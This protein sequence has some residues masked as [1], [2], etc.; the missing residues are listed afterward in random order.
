VAQGL[1]HDFVRLAGISPVSAYTE[2][3]SSLADAFKEYRHGQDIE[4]QQGN[5]K[6]GSADAEGKEVRQGSEETRF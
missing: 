4:K 5:K 3:A 2:I 1:S 6:A